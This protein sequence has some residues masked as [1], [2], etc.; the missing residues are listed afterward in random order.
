MAYMAYDP[1]RVGWLRDALRRSVDTLQ[2]IRC[3]DPLAHAALARVQASATV[4][5]DV[6]LPVVD[7]LLRCDALTAPPAARLESTDL[8]DAVWLAIRATGWQ[9]IPDPDGTTSVRLTQAEARALGEAL[10]GGDLDVLFDTPDELDWLRR[11]L[12]AIIASPVLVTAFAQGLDDWAWLFDVVTDEWRT[13]IPVRQVQLESLIPLFAGA[14]LAAEPPEDITTWTPSIIDVIEPSAAAL[15]IR[16]LPA[17]AEQLAT[18]C[19]QILV[20][21]CA[22]PADRSSWADVGIPGRTTADLLFPLLVARPPAAAAFLVSAAA[23]P[24]IVFTTTNDGVLVKQLLLTGTD[25]DLIDPARAGVVIVAI[26][27]H[28]RR[29]E[30]WMNDDVLGGGFDAHD[31]LGSL[32]APWLA[33]M[34]ARADEWGWTYDEAD[35]ALRW[36]IK[37]GSSM[38]ALLVAMQER[39]SQLASMPIV[40][41]DGTLND[42]AL[43]DLATMFAQLN[44]AFRDEEIDDATIDRIWVDLTLDA[45][46]TVC[47]VVSASVSVP[48]VNAAS[49]A[50]PFVFNGVEWVVTNAG[51]L[52]PDEAQATA[53]A[54]PRFGDRMAAT[55]VVAV[56]A[57]VAQLVADGRL[58]AAAADGLNLDDL[59]EGCNARAVE[60][61]LT[62]YVHTLENRTDAAGF[63]A[64]EAVLTTFIDPAATS[65][66]CG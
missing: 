44:L 25:P 52:P 29:A 1:E 53:I 22:Q 19:D 41:L 47:S 37:D 7:R 50:I 45:I 59:D 49:T 36:V 21:W 62:D 5:S 63:N 3:D 18:W 11:Q 30:P 6:W 43:H 38:D 55:A 61:R 14:Y 17:S 2:M 42:E 64:V 20:R 39:Q 10:A 33:F 46:N 40:G 9:V 28:V 54:R 56:T 16:S 32:I 57:A 51:W 13:A 27:D 34:G 23:H 66:A 26:I 4:I 48:W 35:D 12:Q 24:Q 15:L 65:Q 58:D 60:R 31:L 8:R